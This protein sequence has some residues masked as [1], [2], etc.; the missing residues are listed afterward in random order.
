MAEDLRSAGTRWSLAIWTG[1]ATLLAVP[2]V[3]MRF[4]TD[5][6]WTALDFTTFGI[7]LVAACGAYEF[8]ARRS[9]SLAYR[10]GAAAAIGTAFFLVWVNIAV[11][12]I[13]DEHN[14]ANLMYAGVLLVAIIGA[15][16]ARFRASGMARAM[17][18]TAVAQALVG[19]I[20]IVERLDVP[21]LLL[22]ITALYVVLWMLAS[23]LFGKAAN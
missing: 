8:I 18:A 9:A 12:V 4:T 23:V 15:I 7:M 13:G 19:G 16:A 21:V 1:A 6:Q 22:G 17:T 20:A 10:A 2:A 11:G 14:P 3:A 5:V